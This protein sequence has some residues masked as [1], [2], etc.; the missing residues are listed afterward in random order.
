V[1]AHEWLYSDSDKALGHR[2]RYEK[3]DLAQLLDDSGFD[4][5][6]VYE[7]NRLGV[8]GWY[9]NKLSGRTTIGKWQARLF[10]LL[11]PVAKLVERIPMLPGLSVVAVARRR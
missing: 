11:L 10:G 6:K 2:L 7:F 1:P 4:V 9:V 3:E 5:E 8:L